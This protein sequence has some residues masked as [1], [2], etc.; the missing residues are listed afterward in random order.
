MRRK[1]NQRKNY[2]ASTKAS[3]RD[4]YQTQYTDI[5]KASSKFTQLNPRFNES[6]YRSSSSRRSISRDSSSVSFKDST[7]REDTQRSRIEA[8]ANCLR[9]LILGQNLS[10]LISRSFFE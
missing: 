8:D 7:E 5:C 9:K 4:R 10:A 1:S 2:A 6:Y 3:L